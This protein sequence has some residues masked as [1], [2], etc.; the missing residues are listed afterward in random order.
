MKRICSRSSSFS[1]MVQPTVAY[2]PNSSQFRF[3]NREHC[4]HNKLKTKT[5]T[6]NAILFKQ[7]ANTLRTER[8]I[9]LKQLSK[10]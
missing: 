6:Q 7:K 4:A 5:Q 9:E 3:L 10:Q 1:L 2:R 8:I